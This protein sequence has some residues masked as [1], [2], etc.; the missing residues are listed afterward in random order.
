ME[1]KVVNTLKT[2]GFLLESEEHFH[3]FDYE[4]FSYLFLPNGDDENYLCI[5][6]PCIFKVDEDNESVAYLLAEKASSVLKYVKAYI[7]NGGLMLSYERELFGGEDYE[8]MLS[9][10]IVRLDE[11]VRFMHHLLSAA[12]GTEDGFSLDDEDDEE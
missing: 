2:L 7:F 9:S 1:E 12:D 8:K 6:I 4:G 10:M 11:G 5:S 3:K